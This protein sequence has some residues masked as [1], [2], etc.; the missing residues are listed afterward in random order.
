MLLP[1]L[2]EKGFGIYL[3]TNGTVSQKLIKIVKFYDT[4]S[5]DFKFA[6]EHKRSF[7][8]EYKNFLK[9]AKN[10]VLGRGFCK[11]RCN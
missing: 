8:K 10:K 1:E 2:R 4:V 3:E 6:S 7:L 9:I 11:V 5:V